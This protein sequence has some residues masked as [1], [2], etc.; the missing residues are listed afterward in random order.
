VT[1][2]ITL[3]GELPEIRSDLGLKRRGQHPPRH[4]PHDL[5]DQ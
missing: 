4:L 5:I 2:F 1:A 3:V